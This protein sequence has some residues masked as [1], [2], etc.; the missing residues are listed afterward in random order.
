MWSCWLIQIN[1]FSQ[2]QIVFHP[3][4]ACACFCSWQLKHYYPYLFI[5]LEILKTESLSAYSNQSFQSES[6]VFHT[7]TSLCMLL[8]TTTTTLLSFLIIKLEILKTESLSAHLNQSFQS[9]SNSVHPQQACAC[10]CSWQ[11]KHYYPYIIN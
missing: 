1:H 8:L 6:K 10:F 3:Q 5:K 11:L 2:S 4:Q 9:E 7:S